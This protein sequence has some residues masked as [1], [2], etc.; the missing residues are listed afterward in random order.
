MT[1]FEAAFPP[2]TIDWLIILPVILVTLTGIVGIT[3]EM[4][5]PKQNNNP[6]VWTSLIGLVAAA[7]AVCVQFGMPFAKTFGGMVVRD[8]FALVAQLLMILSAFLAILFS[9]GYLREKRIP[10]GEFYPLVM[11]AT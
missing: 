5:R 2:P 3:I 4:F 10:F 1:I 11:W 9:E 8:Q 6:I 7:A